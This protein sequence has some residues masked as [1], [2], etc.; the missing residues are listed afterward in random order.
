[1][2]AA[3]ASLIA[4]PVGGLNGIP[5]L[6]QC[7]HVGMTEA[8]TTDLPFVAIGSGQELADPFLAFLRRISGFSSSHILA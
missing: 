1:M 5:E 6:I 2:L 8:A 7:N 3:T 4:V